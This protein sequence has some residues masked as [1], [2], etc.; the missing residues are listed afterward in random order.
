MGCVDPRSYQAALT[1]GASCF[2]YSE[3]EAGNITS[4]YASNQPFRTSV[5]TFIAG[6]VPLTGITVSG[7]SG[8]STAIDLN[9]QSVTTEIAETTTTFPSAASTAATTMGTPLDPT[10][11]GG[12]GAL[13]MIAK[14]VSSFLLISRLF[15]R[16]KITN[17]HVQLGCFQCI[18]TVTWAS[19]VGV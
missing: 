7:S 13:S 17:T 19:C 11:K 8:T 9:V 10:Q 4:S 6:I 18:S 1:P 2:V 12:A 16:S 5:E 3:V 15:Y 14:E